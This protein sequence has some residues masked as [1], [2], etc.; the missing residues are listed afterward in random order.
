[1][2][3]YTFRSL[4]DNRAV[5]QSPE[6]MYLIFYALSQARLSLTEVL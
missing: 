5:R 6:V 4:I 1:M 2:Q 3:G